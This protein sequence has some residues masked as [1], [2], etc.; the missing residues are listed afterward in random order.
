MVNRLGQLA[1]F[2]LLLLAI[3]R[4][5][6][7]LEVHNYLPEWVLI[8]VMAALLGGVVQWLLTQTSIPPI[9]GGLLMALGGSVLALRVSVPATLAYG[10]IP[11]AATLPALGV[12]M[13][14]ASQLIRHGIPPVA[15]EPGLI[16][17]LALLFWSLGAVYAIGVAFNRLGLMVIPTGVVYLQFAVFDRVNA[18][19]GWMIASAIVL[20]LAFAALAFHRRHQV[21]AVRD[22]VGR[23]QALRSSA[24]PL[25]MASVVGLIS[26]VG[27]NQASGAV[28]EYGNL[29]WQ[30]WGGGG[31]PPG[32]GGI[33][34]DR[35]VDLRQRLLSRENAVV[36]RATL[37]PDNPP[38][39]SLYWR[40]E[41][42]D[43][44]DGVGW[45]RSSTQSTPY[46]PGREIGATEHA[47]L[48]T[49]AQILQ[50]VYLNRLAGDVLPTL[51]APVSIQTLDESATI[52]PRNIRTAV[53]GTLFLPQGL[54]AD[55]SYQLVSSYPRYDLDLAG[56]ATGHNGDLSPLFAVA[57]E[58][59]LLN[60]S[61]QP[62]EA[63]VVVPDDLERFTDVPPDTPPALRGIAL[64]RTFGATTDFER[65]WLLEHWLRDSGDFTYSVDVTTGHTSLNL[66]DWLTSPTSPNFRTGYCEQFAATMALLG[67]LVGIPSRVV[68]GFTPGSVTTTQDGVEV[69][70][71]RDTNAHAWVEMW[72][73]GYGW[74]KFDPTP[75]G[76]VA[77]ST[78]TPELDPTLLALAAPI[79]T[80]PFAPEGP[81]D[82]LNPNDSIDPADPISPGQTPTGRQRGPLYLVALVLLSSV[83]PFM[84]RL[85]RQTRLERLKDGDITAAWEEIVDR[86]TDLGEPVSE[87]LTPL[88]FAATTSK[89]LLPLARSYSAAVYGNR[90]GAGRTDDLAAVE[91]WIE[92]RFERGQRI[93]AKFN[94]KSLIR[95]R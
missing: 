52:N 62:R 59:G 77:S 61:P 33:L 65:A 23:A 90:N 80:G 5:G 4:L 11:T 16:A 72:M 12:E 10:V 63:G 26:V 82:A 47:Y 49:S 57:V 30:I 73:D 68:W 13:D 71:V 70:E 15:A 46:Q 40:M 81:D 38:L 78:F 36:F 55:T 54:S 41:A 22:E 35:F 20:V 32:S 66:L 48:G 56:L 45:G 17:L 85:R 37:G 39:E 87:D 86:L 94:P 24:A 7:I 27:A 8:L 83:I 74:V 64:N 43:Y 1:G 19:L 21:G 53:D 60:I 69:I 28:S 92:S 2:V 79:P 44:F 18:G 3:A 75:G 25:I 6:R 58:G 93:R 67:R 89:E 88:E 76:E 42:L 34:F 29:P 50:R 91:M 9:V 95:R 14:L 51:G 84:K 31:G